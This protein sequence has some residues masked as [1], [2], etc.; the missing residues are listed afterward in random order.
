MASTLTLLV[1]TAGLLAAT[2]IDIRTRRIPNALT[3]GMSG[4]GLALA[5]TGVSGISPAAALLGFALG[6]LLMMPGYLLGATGAG[7]VKLMAAVG[8][9]LGPA[10]VVTAFLFTAVAGGVLAIVVAAR[11]GRVTAALAGT[12]QLIAS[13]SGAQEKIRSAGTAHRFAYGP[14]IALGSL[15]A[16]LSA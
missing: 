16:A 10:L 13:P 15:V 4:V 5:A 12:G 8:A 6:L 2:V 7:D 3:A 11:R 1:L 9:V 14:A